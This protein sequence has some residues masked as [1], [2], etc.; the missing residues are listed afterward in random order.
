LIDRCQPSQEPAASIFRVNYLP[1]CMASHP[2]GQQS[3]VTSATSQIPNRECITQQ[4][5]IG[6]IN[7]YMQMIVS[8]RCVIHFLNTLCNFINYEISNS[9][10]YA[11]KFCRYLSDTI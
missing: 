10:F 3:S 11:T 9:T 6:G 5:K 1:N 8:Y 2:I 7:I 4:Q